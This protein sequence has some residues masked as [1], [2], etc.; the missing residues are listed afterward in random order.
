MDGGGNFGTV[1]RGNGYMGGECGIEI[2]YEGNY[3]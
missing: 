1:M 3:H 2:M